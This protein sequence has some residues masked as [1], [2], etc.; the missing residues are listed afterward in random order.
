MLL[1]CTS[2]DV[3]LGVFSWSIFLGARHSTEKKQQTDLDIS[4]CGTS[5]YMFESIHMKLL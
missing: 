4:F 3:V 2:V 1:F 5:M